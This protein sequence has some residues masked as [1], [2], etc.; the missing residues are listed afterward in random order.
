M[1]FWSAA[2]KVHVCPTSLCLHF[3]TLMPKHKTLLTC[4]TS[5]TLQAPSSFFHAVLGSSDTTKLNKAHNENEQCGANKIGEFGGG[6]EVKK[7][8]REL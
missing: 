3:Y 5:Q 8:R 4:S 1:C 7:N 6:G 2:V